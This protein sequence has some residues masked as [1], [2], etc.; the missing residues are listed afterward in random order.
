MGE[1]FLFDRRASPR[2]QCK[3]M[4]MNEIQRNSLK[5]KG[6]TSWTNRETGIRKLLIL[7]GS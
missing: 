1:A 7:K 4:V 6:L 3:G 2:A 5:R